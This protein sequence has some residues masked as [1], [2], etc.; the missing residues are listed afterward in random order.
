[1]LQFLNPFRDVV[2]EDEIQEWYA[3]THGRRVRLV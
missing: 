3:L 2:L 1:L